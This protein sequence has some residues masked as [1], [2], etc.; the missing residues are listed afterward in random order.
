MKLE[1]SEFKGHGASHRDSIDQGGVTVS[2]IRLG[3][4][5]LGRH[6]GGGG[7]LKYG[8]TNCKATGVTSSPKT[9]CVPKGPAFITAW[10]NALS[11]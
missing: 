3:M 5:Q 8:S 4:L 7:G 9:R 1:A 2:G 6:T 11:H 10:Q